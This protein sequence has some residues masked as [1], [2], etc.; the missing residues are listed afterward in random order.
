[1]SQIRK[2]LNSNQQLKLSFLLYRDGVYYLNTE[3]AYV[4]DLE[5]FDRMVSEGE[6]ALRAGQVDRGI[7]CFENA[8]RLYRGG[9]M[10]GFNDGWV[11]EQRVY[12]SEQYLRL[13]EYLV[14]AAQKS[15]EWQQ[16]LQF[17]QQLLREDPFREDI[18]CRVM[19]AH[20]ELGDR[21]AVKEQY[22]TL[23]GL[24][25]KDLGLEPSTRTSMVYRQLLA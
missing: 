21:T 19:R 15:N 2:A 16:S 23:R 9:F 17:A 25:R 10:Q 1:M 20:A 7:R 4:I 12:Y 11:D 13:L 5:D 8:I 6:T 22:E 24:L 14:V 18:H 3:Y